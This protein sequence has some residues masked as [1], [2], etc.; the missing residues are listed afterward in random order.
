MQPTPLFPISADFLFGSSSIQEVDL[1]LL[2]FVHSDLFSVEKVLRVPLQ[3]RSYYFSFTLRLPALCLRFQQAIRSYRSRNALLTS[4]NKSSFY[5]LMLN[6]YI[7][8]EGLCLQFQV[9]LPSPVLKIFTFY[10]S[11]FEVRWMMY[12]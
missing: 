4:H 8:S 1:S 10:L 3:Y 5:L 12:L 2:F 7:S 6:R 9:L 11:L